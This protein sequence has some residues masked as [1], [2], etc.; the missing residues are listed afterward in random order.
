MQTALNLGIPEAATAE[1]IIDWKGGKRHSHITSVARARAMAKR[2]IDKGD[3]RIRWIK[4]TIPHP[5]NNTAMVCIYEPTAK[6]T[7]KIV[8][9]PPVN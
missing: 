9:V 8:Q 4:V 7:W 2:E 5:E 3:K 1:I 6:W